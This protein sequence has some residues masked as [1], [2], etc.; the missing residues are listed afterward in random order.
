MRL[1]GRGARA[2][3]S[4]ACAAVL[5]AP[6]AAGVTV[7]SS[8]WE[9]A[10]PQPQGNRIR[11]LSFAD[12]LGVAA[13]DFGTLLVSRDGGE[14]WR[15]IRSGTYL[16]L[17]RA[18]AIDG[19]SLFAAGACVVLRS[20]DGAATMRQTLLERGPTSCRVT[21]SS[22][23]FADDR[24]GYVALSD[25]TVR[26]SLDGG[27]TFAARA[28][29]PGTRAAGGFDAVTDLR[30][31]DG[32]TGLA[33]TRDGILY[34][35][36]DGAGAWQEVARAGRAIRRVG[37]RPDGGLVAVGDT[38]LYLVSLDGGATWAPR[39]LAGTG[40][41]LVD[42]ACT[43]ASSCALA[44]GGFSVLLTRDD[45][46]TAETIPALGERLHAVGATGSPRAAAAGDAGL[47]ALSDD[48]GATWRTVGSR[49]AGSYNDVVAA[50]DGRVLAVGDAGA[51]GVSGDGGA[52]WAQV[53]LP[54]SADLIDAAF[55]D[56]AALVL[57]A[58]GGLFRTADGG[59]TWAAAGGRAP[60]G[61]G[62][63]AS[64]GRV[65][66]TAGPRGVRRSTDGGATLTRVDGPIA[67]ARLRDVD[68]AGPALIAWGLLSAWR[69]TNG[70][71]TWTRLGLPRATVVRYGGRIEPAG[72][73]RLDFDSRDSGFVLDDTGTLHR[74]RDGGRTWRRVLGV[75]SDDAYAMAFPT[76][77]SGYLLLS[78]FAGVDGGF[79]LRTRD[80][81]RSWVP[82]LVVSDP[83]RAIAARGPAT[84]LLLS[85]DQR[86]LRTTTG[87][88]NGAPATLTLEAGS[89][90]FVGRPPRPILT[91]HGRLRPARPGVV[92]AVKQLLPGAT[93]WRRED[94]V[95]QPDGSFV[96]EFYVEPGRNAF[97]AQWAGDF[98]TDG[99]GTAALEIVVG[100]G[101]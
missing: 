48:G 35:T 47:T 17:T 23:W 68:V 20:D 100:S 24:T 2:V 1:V 98:V 66:V 32:S 84:A 69:S 90:R 65:V 49:I 33:A 82:Q 4:F 34:R 37:T 89:T 54:T 101:G 70:G 88:A 19:D 9:W 71:A 67:S 80:G 58:D 39:P 27:A 15:G 50:S 56:G 28:P 96:A 42:V 5:A 72:V 30:F 87:G 76:A 63:I 52:T 43:G 59:A 38:A 75:G 94:E 25:G 81:G 16:G 31:L 60:A 11:S 62:G 46:A 91:L 21:I 92:V 13:G 51:L 57:A 7:G 74:T 55:L 36:T 86:L 44:T 99:A 14:S 8:G 85:R 29:V 78:E 77:S 97:V 83:L 3:L 10:N 93:A 40:A 64:V 95:V 22:G 12:G 26:R 79:V 73:R 53:A 18:Q 61:A 6:A 45:G 41:S